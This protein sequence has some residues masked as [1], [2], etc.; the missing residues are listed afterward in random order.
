M[1]YGGIRVTLQINKPKPK[2]IFCHR[3]PFIPS[4]QTTQLRC[5]HW[6]DSQEGVGL[7]RTEPG[8]EGREMVPLGAWAGLVWS[9]SQCECAFLFC[10]SVDTLSFGRISWR[11]G[12]GW[13]A[14][15]LCRELKCF[16]HSKL[17]NTMEWIDF[18]EE[19]KRE[20]NFQIDLVFQELSPRAQIL[21]VFFI[22]E[23]RCPFCFWPLSH[24]TCCP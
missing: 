4:T 9:G 21:N 8:E 1:L 11:V 10:I 16:Q 18:G 24:Y 22:M 19:G 23:I 7:L 5:L 17:R 20:Q 14:F 12:V 3:L 15:R 6:Q 2:F 13:K